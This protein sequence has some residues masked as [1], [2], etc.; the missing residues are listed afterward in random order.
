[1]RRIPTVT[2]IHIVTV[3]VTGGSITLIYTLTVILTLTQERDLDLVE[4]IPDLQEITLDLQ[5]ITLDLQADLMVRLETG[6]GQLDLDLPVPLARVLVV[7]VLDHQGRLDQDLV[8]LQDQDV[9]D[10]VDL[11]LQDQ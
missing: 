9:P 3:T 4:I 2:S 11:D 5:E 8:D 6:P 7:R 1:M 10:L